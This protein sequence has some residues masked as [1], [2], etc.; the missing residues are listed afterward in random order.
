MSTQRSLRHSLLRIGAI[1]LAPI[2]FLGGCIAY[3]G[4]T[5]SRA[6]PPSSVKNI[7]DFFAWRA[8][9]VVGRGNID[10]DGVSY[11]VILGRPARFLASGPPAYLFDTN[12]SFFDWTSDMGDARTAKYR[13]NLSGV[14][15][16]DFKREEPSS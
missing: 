2:I 8:G 13:L 12:Q 7:D 4:Y 10:I 9:G 5:I 3:D 14:L 11:T 16:K 6:R 1:V 15:F